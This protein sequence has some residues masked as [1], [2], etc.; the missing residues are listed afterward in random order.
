TDSFLSAASFQYT[1]RILSSAAA[2]G[3]VDE[4]NGLKENVILGKLIPAGTGFRK[5]PPV[6]EEQ[7]KARPT[8]A[9]EVEEAAPAEEE[10]LALP[11][12]PRQRAEE[13]L[14]ALADDAD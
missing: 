4:L 5:R 13:L 12:P 1:I 10:E 7:A 2:E 3:K 9:A 11:P 8:E 14:P 6:P